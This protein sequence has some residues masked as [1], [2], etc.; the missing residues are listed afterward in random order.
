MIQ[1]HGLGAGP[2]FPEPIAAFQIPEKEKGLVARAEDTRLL[3][4]SQ[5]C[6]VS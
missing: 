2:I 1:P 4:V 3:A 5:R 6:H